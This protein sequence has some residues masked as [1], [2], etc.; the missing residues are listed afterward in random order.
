M[1]ELN[2]QMLLEHTLQSIHIRSYKGKATGLLISKIGHN[3][4]SKMIQ[5]TSSFFSCDNALW[6]GHT[7]VE[8]C[9]ENP[10]KDQINTILA[11]ISLMQKTKVHMLVIRML[12]L[13]GNVEST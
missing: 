13:K 9:G 8:C 10:F 5:V 12:Q 6:S 1:L 11:N 7:N 2:T 3:I 4:L